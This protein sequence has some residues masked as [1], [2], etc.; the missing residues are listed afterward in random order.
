MAHAF[1]CP[2][3]LVTAHLPLPPPCTSSGNQT[4]S[5]SS[6]HQGWEVE[7][8][9][10]GELPPPVP[11]ESSRLCPLS[12]GDGWV[13]WGQEGK[14]PGEMAMYRTAGAQGSWGLP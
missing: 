10:Y 3:S 14:G 4:L 2:Q 9:G 5:W 12:R 1:A 11:R 8:A 6:L 13:W 7:P